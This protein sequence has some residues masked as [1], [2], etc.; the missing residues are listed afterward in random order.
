MRSSASAS[1]TAGVDRDVLP[2]EVAGLGEAEGLDRQ[3]EVVT[4]GVPDLVHREGVELALLALGV[5]I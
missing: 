4:G 2:F 3:I 5:G 1:I